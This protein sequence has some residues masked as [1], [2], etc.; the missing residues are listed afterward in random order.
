M[1]KEKAMEWVARL[2][3]GKYE[4][5]RSRLNRNNKTFCCLGILSEMAVEDG[6]VRRENDNYIG[7]S[8]YPWTAGLATDIRKEYRMKSTESFNDMFC[9]IGDTSLSGMNDNGKSFA[10][11]A[12]VIEANWEVL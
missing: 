3:S 6:I 5:G 2:R 9:W 12:D 8:G 10:E 11:I 1:N 4:Q 7:S